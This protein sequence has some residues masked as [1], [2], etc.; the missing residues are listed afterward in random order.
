VVLSKKINSAV[1]MGAKSAHGFLLRSLWVD[2]MFEQ[3]KA[4]W[5]RSSHPERKKDLQDIKNRLDH[6]KEMFAADAVAGL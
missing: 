4:K 2:P 3:D 5:P 1:Q 6:E